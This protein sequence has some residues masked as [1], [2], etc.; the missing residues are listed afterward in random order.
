MDW[1]RAVAIGIAILVILAGI[2][3]VSKSVGRS[4]DETEPSQTDPDAGQG[5][6]GGS[7]TTTEEPDAGQGSGG[8]PPT[9]TEEPSEEPS[10]GQGSG[11]GSP[12]P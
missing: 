10:A 9:T 5:S 11:G 1:K 12:T 8:G 6:G 4:V 7:P 3:F 2:Y